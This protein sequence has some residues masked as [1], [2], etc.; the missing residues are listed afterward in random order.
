MQR[1]VFDRD[2]AELSRKLQNADKHQARKTSLL[3][4]LV[5]AKDERL[6]KAPASKQRRQRRWSRLSC[7]TYEV[8]TGRRTG[9]TRQGEE[10]AA[11]RERGQQH[12]HDQ[13]HAARER[14]EACAC[15]EA[16]VWTR[17][18][19][20]S[21]T[22]PGPQLS[23]VSAVARSI[24]VASRRLVSTAWAS[25]YGWKGSNADDMALKDIVLTESRSTASTSI[26]AYAIAIVSFILLSMEEDNTNRC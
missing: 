16:H 6:A 1:R 15:R 12:F 20:N 5:H 8:V 4:V 14:F 9:E 19:Q 7:S 24:E 23:A 10:R 21:S 26:G 18:R 22:A 17:S 13:E 25:H 11:R 3:A 2:R